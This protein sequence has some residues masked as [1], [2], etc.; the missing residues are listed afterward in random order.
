MPIVLYKVIV[1]Y[2]VHRLDIRLFEM[3][4]LAEKP[5]DSYR[6]FMRMSELEALQTR[7][8]RSRGGRAIADSKL[9][10]YQW[11]VEQD[12]PT[13]AVF[14]YCSQDRSDH[15]GNV[16]WIRDE[17]HLRTLFEAA[18]AGTFLF[19]REYGSHG[20]GL[21]RFRYSGEALFDDEGRAIDP[22]RL[23]S[24][25]RQKESPYLMQ[26][27][28][29]P[30]RDLAAIMPGPSLGTVRVVTFNSG[31]CV[32]LAIACMRIPVGPNVADN[33]HRGRSGNLL[34]DVDVATGQVGRCLIASGGGGTGLAPCETH[35]ETGMEIT[36]YRFPHWDDMVRLIEAATS[37]LDCMY[38]VGWDVALTEQG[39]SLVEVNWRY[40]IEIMQVL[41]DRGL[42]S[43]IT[44]GF[45]EGRLPA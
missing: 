20:H 26:A 43:D 45:A 35:P 13:P 3:Y 44:H 28:V 41:A 34:A 27:A 1:A 39:P 6:E 38:T 36:G 25:L 40:D 22:G 12:L 8:N 11:C 15:S 30:H 32:S 19:K 17:E 10:F 42:R 23:L 24:Q 21:L 7:A 16:P 9:R 31:D 29:R 4:A 14:G 5:V 2:A 18:G 33:F 37:R